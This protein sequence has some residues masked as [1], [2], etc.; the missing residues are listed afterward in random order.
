VLIQWERTAVG[1]FTPVG[2]ID[3]AA[4]LIVTERLQEQATAL[5]ATV[6][7]LDAGPLDFIRHLPFQAG[8]IGEIVKRRTFSQRVHM[9]NTFA[10]RIC[11]LEYIFATPEYYGCEKRHSR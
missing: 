1:I 3:A 7:A 10:K 6:S 5:H 4:K 9:D 8:Y 2:R 11:V